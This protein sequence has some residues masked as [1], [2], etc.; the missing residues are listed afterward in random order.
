[1]QRQVPALFALGVA[2]L[3]VANPLFLFPHAGQPVYSHS[4][5]QVSESEVPAEAD[6]LQYEA[7]SPE[8]KAAIRDA[9]TDDGVVYGEANRPPEFFYS[10]YTSLNQGLYYVE[11]DGS[12]YQLYT[13]AGGGL[14]PID[15]FAQWAFAAFGLVVGLVAALS[16]R[17]GWRRLPAG[18]GSYGGGLLVAAIPLLDVS[19]VWLF[20]AAVAGVVGSLV[21]LGVV[22]WRF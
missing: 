17:N 18:I 22:A 11:Q 8:A 14:F 10:D 9:R 3:L 6:V 7:L 4:I 16:R 5:E 15:L 20:L 1:M 2:L 12:Y 13:Y 21:A 19:S